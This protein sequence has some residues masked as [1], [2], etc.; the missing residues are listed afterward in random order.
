M[1][2]LIVLLCTY[3]WS[4]KFCCCDSVSFSRE[5]GSNKTNYTCL[6]LYV[7]WL[8]HTPAADK[9]SQK[10]ISTWVRYTLDMK[11]NVLATCRTS[12]LNNVPG[13]LYWSTH[14]YWGCILRIHPVLACL[15]DK[16]VSEDVQNLAFEINTL[17]SIRKYTRERELSS[18]HQIFFRETYL[19]LATGSPLDAILPYINHRNQ[20][21]LYHTRWWCFSYVSRKEITELV[22]KTITRRSKDSQ[23]IRANLL[24]DFPARSVWLHSAFHQTYSTSFAA[25]NDWVNQKARTYC[26]LF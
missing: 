5:L 17:K 21:I 15:G 2:T 26:L 25:S 20:W 16:Y 8:T 9:V 24:L 12:A 10:I 14:T 3:I 23:S 13:A 7:T 11:T 6:S 18:N 22:K 4:S 1:P 19:Y